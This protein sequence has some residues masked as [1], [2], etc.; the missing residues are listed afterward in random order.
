LFLELAA[1]RHELTFGITEAFG[2]WGVA[3]RIEGAP[4]ITIEQ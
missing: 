3:A 1:G 4:E 2:G